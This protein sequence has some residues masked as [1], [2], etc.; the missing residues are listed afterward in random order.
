M[1]RLALAEKDFWQ[2]IVDKYPDGT[3]IEIVE[4]DKRKHRIW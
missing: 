1:I 4:Y 2:K 3:K